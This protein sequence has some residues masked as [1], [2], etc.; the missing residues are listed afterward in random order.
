MTT[1]GEVLSRMR[2]QFKAVTP[3]AFMTDRF[4]YSLVKKHAALFLRRQ[5]NLNR[6]MKFNSVFQAL[7]FVELIEV[8]RAESQCHGIAS[9]CIIKRTKLKIPTL[10]EG[11]YGPLIRSVS[12]IDFSEDL[13]PTFPSTYESMSRQK[14][15]KYNS[16]KYFWYLNGYLYFPNLQWDAIRLE[17]VFE[18]DVSKYNC[19]PTDDCAYMQ[20]SFFNVPDYLFPEIE[21]AVARDLGVRM[22]IPE[23][24]QHDNR[25]INR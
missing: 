11:Y 7:D 4:L 23:D 18:G 20:D 12:S 6:I 16:K 2:N 1:I 21:Q 10:L 5:D 19:D 15:F 8:D 24:V 17:G 25:N 14:T 13:T 22:Q 9:G 3:D